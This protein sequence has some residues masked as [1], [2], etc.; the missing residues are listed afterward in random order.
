MYLDSLEFLDE[1]REAWRPFEALGALSDDALVRP[2]SGAHG[3][4]GRDLMA[5]LTA[6][7]EVALETAKE[8][9]V[10]ETSPTRDAMDIAWDERGGDVINEEFLERDRARPLEE[11]K[12]RFGSIPGELRGYLTV[13]PESRWVKHPTHLRSFV[14]DTIEHYA[15]H[16]EDLEAVLASDT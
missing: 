10:R 8:L 1:E 13:V 7:H 3:W 5:H 16:V 2:V 15:S 11:V 12:S 14:E 9:A 6:W 4:S